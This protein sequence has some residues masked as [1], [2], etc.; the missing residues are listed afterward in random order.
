MWNKERRVGKVYIFVLR[1]MKFIAI[2]FYIRMMKLMDKHLDN[3][4]ALR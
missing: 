1:G 2:I 3:R 4:R